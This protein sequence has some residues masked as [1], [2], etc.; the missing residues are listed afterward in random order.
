MMY[1]KKVVLLLAV[2]KPNK[3]VKNQHLL[4]NFTDV[5]LKYKPTL[6]ECVYL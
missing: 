5:S 3:E 1:I 6:N 2:Q 4:N